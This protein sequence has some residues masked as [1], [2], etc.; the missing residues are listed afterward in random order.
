MVR[1]AAERAAGQALGRLAVPPDK[2]QPAVGERQRVLILRR[3]Q[4]VSRSRSPKAKHKKQA[5][6]GGER[7]GREK[8]W[9]REWEGGRRT[10]Y[11]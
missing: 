1:V 8:G 3:K 10:K 2:L 5:A 9:E 6:K 7:R 4:S 11:L